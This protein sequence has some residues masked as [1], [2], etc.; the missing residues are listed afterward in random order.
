MFFYYVFT[1]IAE[2]KKT[3][4][5]LSKNAHFFA[6]VFDIDALQCSCSAGMKSALVDALTG[7]LT[8]VIAGARAR[9]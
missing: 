4:S 1:R 5:C 9:A 6:P 2:R 8:G 3:A 7:A